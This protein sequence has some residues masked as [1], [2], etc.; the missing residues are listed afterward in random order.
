VW[1][2]N[3]KQLPRLVGQVTQA[4]AGATSNCQAMT[5]IIITIAT[6]E[7]TAINFTSKS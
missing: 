5:N 1:K 2:I 3:L 6:T 4:A 7:V